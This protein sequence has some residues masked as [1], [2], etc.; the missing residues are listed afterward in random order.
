MLLSASIMHSQIIDSTLQK[1]NIHLQLT[2]DKNEYSIASLNYPN[3]IIYNYIQNK[4]GKKKSTSKNFPKNYIPFD[5]DEQEM[6]PYYNRLLDNKKYN[7]DSIKRY[8]DVH[9]LFDKALMWAI[10]SDRLKDTEYVH[11]ANLLLNVYSQDNSNI[12]GVAHASLMLK[13]MNDLNTIHLINNKEA[14]NQSY[15]QQSLSYL[16]KNTCF[17]DDGMEAVLILI[18]LDR[19]DL[20][21]QQWINDIII[22][23]QLDGGWKWNDNQEQSHQHTSIL[24]YWILNAWNHKTDNPNPNWFK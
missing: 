3:R 17:S 20:I 21:N 18:L 9:Q 16:T 11:F 23:Q 10:Y 2:I 13:W 12:R 7:L 6:Y 4:I 19:I 5:I 24:A 15:I 1:A 8:L 14:L 22:H